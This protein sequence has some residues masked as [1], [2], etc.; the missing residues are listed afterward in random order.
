MW[1]ADVERTVVYLDLYTRTL[2]AVCLSIYL[3]LYI[4]DSVVKAMYVYVYVN[5]FDHVLNA[6]V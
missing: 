6:Q 2:Q 1:L 4:L 5:D 3:V